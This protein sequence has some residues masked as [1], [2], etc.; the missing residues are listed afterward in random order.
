MKKAIFLDRDGT[1]NL[2]NGYTYK[3]S[4]W[5]WIEGSK[6]AIKNF[7]MSGFLVFI[8]T[9]Q[10]GVARGYYKKT[11]IMLLHNYYNQELKNEY[12][13]EFDDI[14]FCPHHPNFGKN[15]NCQCRKPKP[16]LITDLVRKYKIDC[17]KSWMIGD[18]I[19]DVKAGYAAGLKTCLISNRLNTQHITFKD[20]LSASQFILG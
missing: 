10:S 18:K 1:I 13:V 6:I 5:I 7:K 8:I 20:L 9:N 14:A 19:S 2:D 15:R 16:K 12:D 3:I 17:D 4:D 11:D